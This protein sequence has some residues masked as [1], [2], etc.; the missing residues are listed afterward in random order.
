[1]KIKV[2]LFE[3]KKEVKKATI[4]AIVSAFS[5][6]IALTWRDFISNYIKLISLRY[7]FLSVLFITFICVT[8]IFITTK[9][10]K[11]KEPEQ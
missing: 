1:M 8:G 9:L 6:L 4:T 10:F 11:D 2:S 5:F 3:Y 7:E